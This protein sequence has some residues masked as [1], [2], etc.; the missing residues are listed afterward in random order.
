MADPI[1]IIGTILQLLDTAKKC[2]D[3]VQ[4]ARKL[5]QAFHEIYSQI[6]LVK[7]T[8]KE[9]KERYKDND[10]KREITDVLTQCE[11]DT[12]S[13]MEIYVLVSE[14]TEKPWAT[15]YAD[16]IKSMARDRKGKVEELW[17]RILGGINV[18]QGFHVFSSLVTRDQI[19]QA[20]LR[21][22]TVENSL[23][24][25][26]TGGDNYYA[27][28]ASTHSGSGANNSQNQLN[29]GSGIQFMGGTHNHA[30]L[31]TR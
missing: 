24:D 22:E 25:S 8:F 14:N 21:I 19:E 20:L 4:G 13:L 16:Y 6:D 26:N 18:L 30:A 28:V 7:A 2:Y 17:A 31:G 23:S 1:G 12:R 10:D 5:R 29:T 3:T 15:R 9:I 27:P 11:Q